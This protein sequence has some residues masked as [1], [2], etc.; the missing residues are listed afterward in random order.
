MGPGSTWSTPSLAGLAQEVRVERSMWGRLVDVYAR[1]DA[2]NSVLMQRDFLIGG[3]LV[4]TNLDWSIEVN[5]VTSPRAAHDR[6]GCSGFDGQP[7]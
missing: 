1:D 5:A 2:G 7:R 3:N 4:G 6:A